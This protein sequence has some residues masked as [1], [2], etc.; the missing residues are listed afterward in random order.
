MG[1]ISNPVNY[2]YKVNFNFVVII[3]NGSKELFK[4]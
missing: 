1:K 4:P 2:Y 3:K